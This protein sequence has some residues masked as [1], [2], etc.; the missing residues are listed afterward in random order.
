MVTRIRLLND[1]KRDFNKILGEKGILSYTDNS[2]YMSIVKQTEELLLR[3]R[4]IR[5]AILSLQ[6]A[7]A[8]FVLS[9]TAIAMN[10]FINAE[11][12]KE[13]PLMI[14]VG[15]MFMVLAG[16]L[17]SAQEIYRS[18]KIILIEVHAE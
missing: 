4:I 11:L 8:L 10:L 15:G 5:N 14:F 13:L 1:E 12:L 6:T 16:I 3:T 17:F 9:S 18:Y 2:R 7:V